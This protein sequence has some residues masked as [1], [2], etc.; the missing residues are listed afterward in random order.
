[1]RKTLCLALVLCMA[2]VV[3][4]HAGVVIDNF[5]SGDVPNT[6]SP[7]S[8]NEPGPLAGTVSGERTT[9]LIVGPNNPGGSTVSVNN[10]AAATL[11]ICSFGNN[12]GIQDTVQLQYAIPAPVDL[13]GGGLYDRV[14]FKFSNADQPYNLYLEIVGTGGGNSVTVGQAASGGV[15]SYVDILFSALPGADVANATMVEISLTPTNSLGGDYIFDIIESRK[16]P[17]GGEVPEPGAL[18]LLS[19]GLIGLLRRKRS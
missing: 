7:M 1:M 13:T 19:G 15:T 18:V 2:L 6:I 9:S 17:N 5:S 12:P 3:S 10:V 16:P 11:G 8:V 4:A 14:R